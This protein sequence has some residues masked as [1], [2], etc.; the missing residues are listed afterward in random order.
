MTGELRGEYEAF[1]GRDF[2][3][4]PMFYLAVDRVY[5]AIGEARRQRWGR[6]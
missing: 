2:S 5:E 3:D 6:S 1:S 4:L